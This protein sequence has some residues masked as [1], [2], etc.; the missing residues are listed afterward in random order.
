MPLKRCVEIGNVLDTGFFRDFYA[1]VIVR[2]DEEQLANVHTS[3]VHE[4]AATDR[5][6][7]NH[8]DS[9][10]VS[11]CGARLSRHDLLVATT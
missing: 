9:H 10:G 5:A 2:F 6:A 3:Q 11:P 4:M 1:T 8:N 7:A